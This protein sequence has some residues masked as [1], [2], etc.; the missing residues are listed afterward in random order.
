MEVHVAAAR[1]IALS[2]PTETE[3]IGVHQMW[4]G[5]VGG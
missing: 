4:A 3:N 5:G 2:N 1:F